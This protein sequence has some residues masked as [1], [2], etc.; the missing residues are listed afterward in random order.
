MNLA[1]LLPRTL[2]V[3]MGLF[4]VTILALAAFL[5]WNIDRTLT[6]EFEA[7]GKGV[8]ENIA[9]AGVETLLN[10][11]PATVQAMIDERRDGTPGLAYI[12]VVDD[13]DEVVAHTFVPRVPA[14]VRQHT[15]D[16]HKTVIGR[17][18]G[19]GVGD[20]INI[21]SPI[22]AGQAG[23]VHVGMDRGPIRTA[24]WRS[25]RQMAAVLS[26]LFV[27][28][29]LATTLLMRHVTQPLRQLT[30]SAQRLASSDALTT[31]ARG[32]LPD[33]FP[34]ASGRDEVSELTQAFRSMAI[35]VTARESNLKEQFKLLLDSTAEA[36]YGVDN[37]GEC[38]FCN[39]A[40][41]QLLGYKT[42]ADLLG[43]SMHELVHCGPNCCPIE[44]PAKARARQPDAVVHADNEVFQRADGTSFPVE[45]WSHPMCREDGQV[46]GSV[47]TFVEISERKRMTAE[48][49]H[50]KEAAEAA[51]R[52]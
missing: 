25:I 24:I 11:D 30:A 31:G 42:T 29:A 43:K 41:V 8:A 33:W 47:V 50:A 23:Y 46:I 40:C 14:N 22:L 48:L 10:R 2:L 4:G 27:T 1:G 52:A 5:A 26:I 35:E 21:C 49:H 20:C 12:L 34:T 13:R 6:A 18:R 39:P 9:G 19:E 38:V 32:V 3:L 15:G 7:K 17:T 37:E 28:G 45:Y 16:P 51:N 44:H 36:I